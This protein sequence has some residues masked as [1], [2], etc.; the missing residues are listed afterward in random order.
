MMDQIV[1]KNACKS[2]KGRLVLDDVCLTLDAGN[3]Y[4]FYGANGSGKTMLFR[5]IA[6]L[7]RLDKGEISVFSERI[8]TDTDFPKNMGLIIEKVGFWDEFTGFDN[9]KLLASIQ[10]KIGKEGIKEAMSR[11]GLDYKDRR[12]YKRY[13]LG[14]KQRLGIAQAIMERL[15][16]LILDEPTNAL[17]EDGLKLIHNIICEERQKGVTILLASHN[18]EELQSL[19]QKQYKMCDGRLQDG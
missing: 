4:G 5:A 10:R 18:A 1:I 14:M 13:S 16:L 15:K 6:G 7:I 19:C 3:V 12:N 17:D 11:V 9:L 8:G 2:I